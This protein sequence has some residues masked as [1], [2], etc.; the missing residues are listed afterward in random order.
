MKRIAV[1]PG[2]GIGSEVTT[3][4]IKVLQHY[5]ALRNLKEADLTHYPWGC[6]YYHDKGEMMPQN[7]LDT[8]KSYDAILLGAVGYPGVP[9]H[10]SLRDLLLKIRQG[11]DQSVNLRPIKLLKGAPCPLKN[12]T[13]EDIDFIVIREN[14]EGEYSGDG[15]FENMDTEE[16]TAYQTGVFTKKKY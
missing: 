3:E 16:A 11:F 4:G 12:K 15:H 10:V 6:K 9:D 5:L 8:L 14:V 2:D 13:P 1:I 7:A